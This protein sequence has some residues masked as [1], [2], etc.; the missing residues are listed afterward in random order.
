MSRNAAEGLATAIGKIRELREEYW[1]DVKV[2]GGTEEINQSLEKAGRVA[3]FFELAE[4]MCIDALR[5]RRI[6]RRAISEKSIKPRTAKRCATTSISA[7][8]RHGNTPASDSTAE[9]AQRAADLRIRASVA[10]ELQMRAQLEFQ[11]RTR[12]LQH[13]EGSRCASLPYLASEGTQRRGRCAVRVASMNPDMSMLEALDVLNEELILQGE[14]PITFEHDCREGIC[15]SCG[16]MINGVAH[17]P[18]PKTT[19]CQLTLRHFKDGEELYLEPW[20]ARAFPVLRDLMVDRAR[21]R[22]DHRVGRIH[23][24]S[25]QAARRMETRFRCRRTIP[26]A[27]WMRR[28]ASAA[29]PAWRPVR[30]RRHRYSPARRSAISGCCRRASRSATR[31]L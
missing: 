12:A 11:M 10:T 19:V 4:L 25:A 18:L 8:W 21:V 22:P 14:E 27:P 15:G 29:E 20:R 16:F 13:R 5:A 6:L 26:I 1:R 30:T 17:G 31:E 24:R 23:L 2:L 9:A 7:T 3:D 28:P